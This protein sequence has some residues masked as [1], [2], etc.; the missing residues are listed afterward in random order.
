MSTPEVEFR[1]ARVD[2]GDGATLFW[3]MAAEIAVLYDGLDHNAPDM[4]KAGP[5]E[6]GPPGGGFWVGYVAAEPAC[7]GG[8]KR[9]DEPGACE[10]K[11]MY[12]VPAL[13]GR[14]LA[15]RL[16]AFLEG[17]AWD[18]GYAVARLDTGHRQPDARHL[19]E[20][21]GY[22]EIGNFNANPVATYFAQKALLGTSRSMT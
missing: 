2:E 1:T 20:S 16:L 11:R 3:A 6:L 19:Y 13:R 7:C 15:H 17:Q 12:V 8:L 5:A 18:L 21:T 9:L 4:P 10:I 14:G 22:V